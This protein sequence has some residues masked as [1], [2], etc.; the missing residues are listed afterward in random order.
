MKDDYKDPLTAVTEA[1]LRQTA[2]T[3]QKLSSIEEQD[4][5]ID[6]IVL[7]LKQTMAESQSLTPNMM[8]D[9]ISIQARLLDSAFSQQMEK[10]KSN[11]AY[12]GSAIRLQQQTIRTLM[13]WKSLKTDIYVRRKTIEIQR[14]E[15]IRDER[16]EQM[17]G[18]P[19]APSPPADIGEVL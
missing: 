6:D 2:G 1:Q 7:S 11:S 19:H 14:S 3:L 18:P 8:C 13:A 15:K 16:T 17:G 10:A 12:F 5:S 4:A 9:L